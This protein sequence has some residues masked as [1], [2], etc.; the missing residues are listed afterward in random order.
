MSTKFP[1][2]PFEVETTIHAYPDRKEYGG[3]DWRVLAEIALMKVAENGGRFELWGHGWELEKFGLWRDFADLLR[4]MA[5][6]R[7]NR[8]KGGD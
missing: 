3:K 1:K 6:Y 2:K 4:L 7:N 8:K 5:I